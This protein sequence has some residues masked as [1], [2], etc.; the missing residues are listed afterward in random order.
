MYFGGR[1]ATRRWQI[2]LRP[3]VP[4]LNIS[5]PL[6]LARPARKNQL[7]Q[8]FFPNSTQDEDPKVCESGMLPVLFYISIDHFKGK[9]PKR[10]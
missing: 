9:L 7:E 4:G 8:V 3:F 2:P 1:M 10:N 6:T 5:P